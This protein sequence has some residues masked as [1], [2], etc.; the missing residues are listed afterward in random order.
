MFNPIMQMLQAMRLGNNPQVIAQN[1]M[2][3]NPNFSAIAQ[4]VNPQDPKSIEQLCRNIC[5][6]NN[7]DF[8]TALTRFKQQSG[9][10]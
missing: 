10:K 1:L 6:Q 3:Q 7:I 2:Q 5:A 4:Q 8:N 9:I